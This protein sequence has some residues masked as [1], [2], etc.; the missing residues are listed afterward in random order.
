MEFPYHPNLAKL[1]AKSKIKNETENFKSKVFH[2]FPK[3]KIDSFDLKND[4][5]KMHDLTHLN[6]EGAQDV[7]FFLSPIL[8]QNEKA[9]FIKVKY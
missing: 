4:R 7:S 6:K 5:Q 2:L 1:E 8:K 3:I 9:I